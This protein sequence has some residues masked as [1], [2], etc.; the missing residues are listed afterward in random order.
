MWSSIETVAPMT[1]TT[2]AKD[3]DNENFSKKP[4]SRYHIEYSE[5]SIY[6]TNLPCVENTQDIV[7]IIN[8]I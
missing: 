7:F 4:D 3:K 8:E 5:K 6:E 2:V 1:A